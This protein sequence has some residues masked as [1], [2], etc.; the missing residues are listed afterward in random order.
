MAI[1]NSQNADEQAA[2]NWVRKNELYFYL[3]AVLGILLFAGL[4]NDVVNYTITETPLKTTQS[5]TYII[6]VI[7]LV[8]FLC[9]RSE[10]NPFAND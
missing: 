9:E 10:S 8:F 2:S 3:S 4:I 7:S 6:L 5:F 1:L